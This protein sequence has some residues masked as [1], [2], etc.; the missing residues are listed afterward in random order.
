MRGHSDG[1]GI[2]LAAEN[3]G[4]AGLAFLLMDVRIKTVMNLWKWIPV[5]VLS[6]CCSFDTGYG[7]DIAAPDMPDVDEY[8]KT[9]EFEKD[10]LAI[11]R[12]AIIGKLCLEIAGI[13]LDMQQKALDERLLLQTMMELW[14]EKTLDG[15]PQDFREAWL[16]SRK[17]LKMWLKDDNAWEETEEG[18]DMVQQLQDSMKRVEEKYGCQVL[19]QA[20][21][22]WL[23]ANGAVKKEG[24]SPEEYL[25]RLNQ[26]KEDIYSGKLAV[27]SGLLNQEDEWKDEEE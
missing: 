13:K 14:P 25:K 12:Q 4:N 7:Q 16:Q 3:D 8:R 5:A 21:D 27:S 26:L 6:C 19:D 2:G 18:R 9:P 11:A 24:E 15:C 10:R 1:P 23:E 20:A 17:V 22:R